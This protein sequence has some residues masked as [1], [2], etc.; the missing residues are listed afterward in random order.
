MTVQLLLLAGWT[1]TAA[2]PL[3]WWVRQRHKVDVWRY[4]PV[5]A[6]L[7]DEGGR[8][9]DTTGS[10]AAD[11]FVLAG[12]LPALGEVARVR[13]T[14][15]EML[16]VSGV[17]GGGL[18][19]AVSAN[20]VTDRRDRLLADLG[21]RL[22]HEVNTPLA[23]VTGH[24]DL[25][26]HEEISDAARRSVRICQ[27]EIDRIAGLT[28]DLLT[29]TSVRAGASPRTRELAGALVE[30]AVAG[31][32]PLADER[33]ADIAVTVP[34]E[35]VYVDV[36]AGD[37]I[38]CVRTL[39]VNA[40]AHGLGETRKV[41]V[42][43]SSDDSSV[44][45]TVTD[46]GPGLTS[47]DLDRLSQPLVRGDGVVGPGTGLGLAIASEVLAAHGSHLE[48]HPRAGAS[49]ISFRLRRMTA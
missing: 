14:D 23:A 19:V 22:A 2:V 11:R 12:A 27:A 37:M 40:L 35:R 17:P 3:A 9:V 47:A 6:A 33:G 16:A 44:V 34:A 31:V 49:S 26:A 20:P 48:S 18:A 8:V 7:I 29:L 46:S 21:P 13:T 5:P 38:R 30:E 4:L 43:V 1:I 39:V 10:A 42:G 24:L 45:F 36:A 32:L 41:H 28:R 15:G 25:V